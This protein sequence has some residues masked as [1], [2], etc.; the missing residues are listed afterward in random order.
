MQRYRINYHWLIGFFVC[1]LVLAVTAF[2]V[3]SWQVNRKA[4]LFLDRAEAEATEGNLF[5]AFEYYRKYVQL[6]PKEEDARLKMAQTAADL[7][8]IPEVTIEQL[9]MALGALDETVR[10]TGDAKLRRELAEIMMR[11][12]RTQDA[13]GHLEELLAETPDDIELNELFARAMYQGK[14][15]KEFTALAYNLV[16]YDKQTDAFDPEKIKLQEDSD[17]YELLSNVLL[18]REENPELARRVIDQ[19][20]AVNSESP[21]AHLRKSVFLGKVGENEEARKFLDKAYELDPKNVQVLARKGLIALRESSFEEAKEYYAIGLE[22]YEDSPHFYRMMAEVEQRLE[23]PDAAMEVLDQGIG[24]LKEHLSIELILYKIEL[25]INRKD[26]DGIEREIERLVRLDRPDLVPLIDFQKARIKFDQKKW[27]EVSKELKR[28][29]PLLFQRPNYFATAGAPNY[30]ALA[31]V[32]LGFSYEGQGIFDLALQAYDTV[33]IDSPNNQT[34]RKGRKRILAKRQPTQSGEGVELTQ[35]VDKTLEL[36]EAEQDWNKVDELIEKAIA[37]NELSEVHQKLLRAKV[38][39]KRNKYTEATDL[40]RQAA[41]DAPDDI[42]IHFAAILLVAS[43]PEQGPAAALKQ[44][45]RLEKRWGRSLRSQ[46]QRADLLANLRPEDIVEQLRFLVTDTQDLTEAEQLKFYK[47]IGLKFE[48]L[49][50]LADAREFYEK[51]IQLEPN[52][53]PIRMHL[54]NLALRQRDD[55]AMQAAQEA[56]LDF[57]KSKSDP[58]YILTEVRRRIMSFSRREIDRTQ[59]TSARELLDSALRQR[60]KWHELHIAYGQLLLVLKE[61]M[62]LALKYFDDALDYGPPNPNAVGIQIRLLAEQGLYPQAFERMNRLR[63]E[64]RGRVLGQL[65]A[66]ILMKTGESEEGFASAEKLA[67]KQ[68]GNPKTQLWF[69]K[70]AQ[71]LG[72][73]DVAVTALRRALEL[74]PSDPDNWLR[75]IGLYAE[76]KN[77]R[78]VEG[79]IREAHLS[80]DAEYLPLLTGKHYEMLSRWQNAEEIYLA[81]YADQLNQLPVARRMADFYL[82]WSSKDPAN[83]QRAATYIN[84]ILRAA[85]VG[86]A[87]PD[88]PHVVWARQ[89]AAQILYAKKDYQQSLKAERLLRQSAVGGVMNLAESELLADILILRNDPKSLLQAKQLLTEQ[90]EADRLPKKGA[91]QLARILSKTDEW[92]LSKAL[93]LELI[94]NNRSDLQVRTVYVGL[95][96][97]Q[98]EYSSAESALKRFEKLKPTGLTLLQL[99]ARLAS[100]RGDQTQLNKMLKSILPNMRGAMTAAQLKTVLTVAQLATRYGALELAEDLYEK[101]AARVPAEAFQLARFH[102]I[103]GDGDRALELMKRLYSTHTDAVVQLASTMIGTRRDEF[104]DKYDEPMDRLIN[105]ALR[106]DPDSVSRQLARAETYEQQGKNQES[107]AA[108]EKLLARDD[109][110]KRMRAAAMN[111]FGFQLALLNQRVDEAEQLINEAM[112]TFG[113]VEDML[114]TRA[115]VRIAQGEYDLAIEDMELALSVSRDPVKYFH[116]AKA[117][118]LAGDGRAAVKAWEKAQEL[119]FDKKDSLPMLEKATFEQILQKIESVQTQSEKL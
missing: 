18:E 118:I 119:G 108:Y 12:R 79:A 99:S 27:T 91:L 115:I 73:F 56:I 52:N 2:F 96:I 59:L 89:K 113:P 100:Q 114:D 13:I 1:S 70:I 40:I 71:K 16:G 53:L 47:V 14:K 57:V 66:E 72:K 102:A 93:M 103:H 61:D 38:L 5:E 82:L 85:N 22:E 25:L 62:E 65:E 83:I 110:P 105:E 98:G 7:I 34:A 80:V 49:G 101:Y 69:S 68:L 116:L 44:L 23:R 43:D 30:Q 55:A 81:V 107:I 33:L 92:Q 54:F 39:I 26:Y 95:L 11:F 84:R 29:R 63:K 15:Y 46:V 6:R 111:N 31:G 88:N 112:H 28:V 109:L 74:N 32:M 9:S 50:K 19:M 90:R 8:K 10:R 51:S 64:I 58:S 60:P 21:Q 77:I 86:D 78:K 48:Q 94:S 17:I 3:Q 75:L 24:K 67:E 45:D 41:K 35:L 37:D 87:A 117:Y 104:G 42:N 97:D 20:I 4:G 36:P 76:Q 106:E